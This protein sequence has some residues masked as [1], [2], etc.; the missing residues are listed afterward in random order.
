[1]VLG[2]NTYDYNTEKVTAKNDDGK[3]KP[4]LA[5]DAKSMGSLYAGRIYLK[6][7]EKGVGVNSESTMLADVGDFVIDVNGDLVLK[8]AQAKQ[9]IDLKSSNTKIKEKLLSEKSI[10]IKQIE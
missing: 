3:E 7:T 10:K 2:R 5:L 4:K 9:N 6:S 1:M 8:N